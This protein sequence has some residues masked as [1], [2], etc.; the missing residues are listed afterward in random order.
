MRRV[1]HDPGV[2]VGEFDRPAEATSRRP[3][4]RMHPRKFI[5]DSVGFAFSQYLVRF[6]NLVRGLVAARL[7]GPAGYGTWTAILLIMD[8][9][10]NAPFGTYQGLDQVVRAR[11]VDGDA[12]ALD[13]WKRAGLF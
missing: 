3:E 5:R 1:A 8:Y 6:L 13:R 12:R 11:I 4:A 7:L 10:V 9:G 2:E